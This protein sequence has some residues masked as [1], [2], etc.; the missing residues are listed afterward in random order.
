ML[1]RPA[2]AAIPPVSD[3]TSR[4]WPRA[5][6]V[7]RAKKLYDATSI[8]ARTAAAYDSLLANLFIVESLPA[9]ATNRLKRLARTPKR[10]VIDPE[11]RA[12]HLRVEGGRREVDLLMEAPNGRLIVI[13][14]KA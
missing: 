7:R 11:L 3:A 12:Y 14:V 4:R 2:V 5:L 13:E 8:N 10:Y 1:R 6:R 9:W